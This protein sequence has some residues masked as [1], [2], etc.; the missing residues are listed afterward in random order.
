MLRSSESKLTP[1][2]NRLSQ[3]PQKHPP[4]NIRM[5]KKKSE[6]RFMITAFFDLKTATSRELNQPIRRNDI[7]P[8]PSQPINIDI[9]LPPDTRS[10]IAPINMIIFK[11][12]TCTS[13]SFM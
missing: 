7:I 10:I 5:R 1:P 2:E 9:R 11:E 6:K 12:N 13:W 8:T 3:L 4:T